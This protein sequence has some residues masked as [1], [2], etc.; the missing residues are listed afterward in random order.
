MIIISNPIAVQNEIDLIHSLFEE[1][2]DLF[3][4]RKPDFS[5][6]EMNGFISAIGHEYR[7]KLVLH[8]HHHLAK[9][10]GI[11]RFHN[12]FRISN[13]ERVKKNGDVFSASSHSISAFNALPNEIDY[14]FLSPVFTSI[15]KEN[16][17]PKKNLFEQIKKRTNYK[18][19]LVALGG[20]SAKN[21]EFTLTRGFDEVALLGT[22][23]NQRN[24]IENFKLCQKIA[25]S[26]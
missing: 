12:P 9:A 15:S 23:W 1:G 22:I 25:L 10:L 18:T 11:N 4:V 16:Y 7:K 19:Q 13:S 5:A 3:H 24:P 14:A 17:R 8:S 21:M 20:I 26:F 6:T 2:M